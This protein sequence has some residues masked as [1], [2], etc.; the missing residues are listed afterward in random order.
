MQKMYC[1][2]NEGYNYLLHCII[3]SKIQDLEHLE[4]FEKSPPSKR[5]KLR[6]ILNTSPGTGF[7][8][9]LYEILSEKLNFKL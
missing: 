4:H 5:F 8:V 7:N 9:N 3:F 6:L 2:F 1:Y